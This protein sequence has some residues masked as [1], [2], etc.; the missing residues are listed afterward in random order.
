MHF[1]D[2]LEAVFGRPV[3]LVAKSALHPL[4]RTEVLSQARQLYAA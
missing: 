2:L 1:S 4:I 3:D